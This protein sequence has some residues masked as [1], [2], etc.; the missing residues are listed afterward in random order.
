M[1]AS[2]WLN[3]TLLMAALQIKASSMSL[4][5]KLLNLTMLGS[6]GEFSRNSN[7]NQS[8]TLTD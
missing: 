4:S 7:L 6:I 3:G 5:C 1:M 2:Y 8:T